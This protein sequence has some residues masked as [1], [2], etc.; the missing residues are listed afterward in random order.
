MRQD[1]ARIWEDLGSSGEALRV[2]VPSARTSGAGP[3]TESGSVS[4][5]GLG[6]HWEWSGS[7]LGVFWEDVEAL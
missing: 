3:E 4:W 1:E 2:P 7:A 6:V 5:S